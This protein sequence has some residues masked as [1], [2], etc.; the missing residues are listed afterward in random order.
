MIRSNLKEYSIYR[1]NDTLDAY[2]QR[3]V[4]LIDTGDTIWVA[5]YL[6][7]MDYEITNPRYETTTHLA[8][9][10]NDLSPQDYLAIDQDEILYR[11]IGIEYGRFNRNNRV[12]LEELEYNEFI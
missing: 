11:V 5:V 12:M 10:D 8:L 7:G 1:T 4:D 6:Q 2:G 9:T 3:G